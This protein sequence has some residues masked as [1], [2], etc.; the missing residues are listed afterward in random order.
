MRIRI[1]YSKADPLVYTSTL[2]VQ[3]IWERTFRRSGLALQYSKGFHPQ[4]RIQI[5][6]PLP[7]GY[8]GLNEMIDVW[9][10]NELPVKT[11]E[12]KIGGNLPAGIHINQ[13]AMVDEKD[14]S[15]SGLVTY[16]DYV[17]RFYD[18]R[19][20]YRLITEKIGQLLER[21]TIIRE[22]NRKKYDLRPLISSLQLMDSGPGKSAISIRMSSSA[23]KTGR[24]EEVLF[25]LGFGLSD[26]VVERSGL[27]LSTDLK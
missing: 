22:R 8:I 11:I 6:N 1:T 24:P 15:L 27:I 9:L 17:I 19:I 10:E 7:L 14:P 3:T 20:D 18:D 4:A 12:K 25:E 2:N 23:G 16:S 26:F 5:A 13:I 21:D